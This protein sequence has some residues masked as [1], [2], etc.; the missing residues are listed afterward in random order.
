MLQA[1]VSADVSV[2]YAV[3]NNRQTQDEVKTWRKNQWLTK[4]Q[5]G[6]NLGNKDNQYK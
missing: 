3:E 5:I 2:K 1:E 6:I 4:F